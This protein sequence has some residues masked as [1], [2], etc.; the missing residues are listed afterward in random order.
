[1]NDL[2]DILT[3]VT[4]GVDNIETILAN[5]PELDADIQ[6]LPIPKRFYERIIL[7][8]LEV[9][10]VKDDLSI[11][12]YDII[13]C[14]DPDD[15]LSVFTMGYETLCTSQEQLDEYERCAAMGEDSLPTLETVFTPQ[16]LTYDD[17]VLDFI[18]KFNTITKNGYGITSDIL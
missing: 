9:E 5:Y 2:E 17:I 8:H 14:K 3:T 12:T 6:F 11:F 13:L 1:M 4:K 7:V 15:K 18:E 16:D 10:R